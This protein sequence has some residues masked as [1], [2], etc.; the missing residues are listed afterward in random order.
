[1]ARVLSGFRG[2]DEG[3]STTA[4]SLP[5]PALMDRPTIT[6]F[7]E[8]RKAAAVNTGSIFNCPAVPLASA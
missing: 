2:P 5:H 4:N 3:L 7:R 1:M 6:E 8:S